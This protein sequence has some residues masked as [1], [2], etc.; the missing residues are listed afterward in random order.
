M[1]NP[2]ATKSLAEALSR[3]QHAVGEITTD[4]RGQ[5]SDYSTLP[6]VL[7]FINPA[8]RANDLVLT[9]PYEIVEGVNVLTTV[10]THIPTGEKL[11]SRYQPVRITGG[12]NPI[13]AE[14]SGM[15]YFRRYTMLSLLGLAPGIKDD[16]G[17]MGEFESPTS[18]EV[19]ALKPV[20]IAERELNEISRRSI[21]PEKASQEDINFCLSMMREMAKKNP[22]RFADLRDAFTA[23]FG[24][25]Q[26][27][28]PSDIRNEQHVSFIN[29]FLENDNDS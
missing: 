16:E 3:F 12:K 8:L 10:V 25:G 14:G 23:Q 5:H 22:N 21:H 7:G 28:V 26:D 29:L 1:T 27:M 11:V 17:E 9:Q 24:L 13:H 2:G 6:H 20:T 19:T 15:T 4:A 18:G